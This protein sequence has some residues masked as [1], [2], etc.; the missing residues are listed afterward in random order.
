[1]S[2]KTFGPKKMFSLKI[3]FGPKIFGT[4]KVLLKKISVERFLGSAK[5]CAPISHI[6]DRAVARAPI[7]GFLPLP[8]CLPAC[9]C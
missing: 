4:K 8:A 1:M 7:S 2:E 9:H 6:L 3:I 5:A